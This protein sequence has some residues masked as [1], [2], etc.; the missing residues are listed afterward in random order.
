MYCKHRQ[1]KPEDYMFA[2]DGVLIE[3]V[4]TLAQ[5]GLAGSDKTFLINVYHKSM[6]NITH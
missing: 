2:L 3:P 5:I 6:V 1:Y 4:Q